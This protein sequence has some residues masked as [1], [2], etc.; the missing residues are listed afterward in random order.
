MQDEMLDSRIRTYAHAIKMCAS[1][2][3]VK[4]MCI[5]HTTESIYEFDG[6]SSTVLLG[7]DARS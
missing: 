3:G 5:S 6:Y 2:N 4:N 7:H 1:I